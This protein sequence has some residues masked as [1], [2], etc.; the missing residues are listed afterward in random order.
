M[1]TNLI[2]RLPSRQRWPKT[3]RKSLLCIDIHRGNRNLVNIPNEEGMLTRHDRGSV[4][5]Q[6]NIEIFEDNKHMK[7]MKCRNREPTKE[8]S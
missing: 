8:S 1:S 2:R 6:V 3:V 7:L 5:G 4:I